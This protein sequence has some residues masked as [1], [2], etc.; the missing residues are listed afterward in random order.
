MM[1]VE[2]V[3]VIFVRRGERGASVPVIVTESDSPKG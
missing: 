1:K 2:K 3:M